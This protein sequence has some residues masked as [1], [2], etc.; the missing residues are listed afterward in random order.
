MDVNNINFTRVLTQ[1]G[2][3][4][5]SN[6]IHSYIDDSNLQFSTKILLNPS[7]NPEVDTI[8]SL[9]DDFRKVASYAT[10]TFLYF[11]Q[12]PKDSIHINQLTKYN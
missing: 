3:H 2:S 11:K 7:I 12:Q 5:L 8:S 4:D 10:V 1:N 6:T 9:T